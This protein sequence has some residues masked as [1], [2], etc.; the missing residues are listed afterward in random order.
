M[1]NSNRPDRGCDPL[2]DILS[3]GSGG[4]RMTTSMKD[5]L[6]KSGLMT[7][8]QIWVESVC[9][10]SSDEDYDDEDDQN[11]LRRRTHDPSKSIRCLSTSSTDV[12]FES[13]STTSLSPASTRQNSLQLMSRE[14]SVE[15]TS[16]NPE[17]E[18]E[19]EP[20]PEPFPCDKLFT[21]QVSSWLARI[22]ARG[23][24]VE[25]LRKVATQVVDDDDDAEDDAEDDDTW[26]EPGL[27]RVFDPYYDISVDEIESIEGKVGA[28]GRPVGQC[29]V[30][31]KNGDSAFGLF[32]KGQRQGRGA[33]EGAN[34][35]RHG[36][37]GIK[38]FYKDGVL[39]GEG[40]A[41]LAP[42]AWASEER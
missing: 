13:A 6:V 26:W 23:F 21:E 19:P 5:Q 41:I 22:N 11:R 20:E 8:P 10:E 27:V 37:V 35:Y 16:L 14:N 36:I 18:T 2:G 40:R 12:S 31:L 28:D 3:L 9:D 38:G 15:V 39:T 32:R 33:I 24:P 17:P 1:P 34:C 7:F 29:S 4:K 25:L 30:L 42:G